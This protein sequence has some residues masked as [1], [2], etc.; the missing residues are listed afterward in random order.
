M[1]HDPEGWIHV[2]DPFVRLF[3]WSLVVAFAVA[4]LTEDEL[5]GLHAW[6]G[7]AIGALVLSRL[8]WGVIGP[9]RARFSDFV[10]GPAVTLRYLAGLIRF[11]AARH[12]GHSPAGGA[13]IAALLLSL[14]LTVAT[15]LVAYGAGRNAGPLA[16]WFAASTEASQGL[17]AVAASGETDEA[18]EAGEEEGAGSTSGIGRAAGEL[19]ELFANLTLMLVIL[20]VV[21]VIFASVVFRENLARTMVTGF[22]RR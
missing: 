17:P 8:V 9:R 3:H 18:A 21:A 10:R 15:G 16:G 4:W 2:W 14:S 1:K 20:H 19:H 5:I 13:M 6:A 11:R 7:Y 22:K 12:I